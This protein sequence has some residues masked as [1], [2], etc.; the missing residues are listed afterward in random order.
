[1]RS[2][3]QYRNLPVKRKLRLMIM[4]TVCTALLL[5]CAA[6]LIY[7]HAVLHRAVENDLGILSEIFASNLTAALTFDD[8]KAA[9]ESVVRTESA[10]GQRFRRN[11]HGKR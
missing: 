10:A 3:L 11:L 2:V 5:A 6:V 8:P 9:E 7:F 1:M 4:G